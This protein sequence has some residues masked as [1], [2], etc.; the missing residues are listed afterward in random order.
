LLLTFLRSAYIFEESEEI[1][2]RTIIMNVFKK[3]A[4]FTLIEILIALVI[5]SISILA[6]AG[7]TVTATRTGAYGGRMTEAVTFAQDK[8]EELKVNSWEKIVSGADQETGPT[9]ISYT[10]KWKVLEKETRNLKTVSITIDW[11]DRVDHSISLFTVI[12]R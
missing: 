3:T 1:G 5:F 4:G 7:L 8:L 9:G 12:S 2:K 10:R 11:N 6:F